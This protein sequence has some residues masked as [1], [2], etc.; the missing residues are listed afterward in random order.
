MTQN[1]NP[2]DLKTL[3]KMNETGNLNASSIQQYFP[4]TYMD[5]CKQVQERDEAYVVN[6]Y[7]G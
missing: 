6:R 2:Y 5:A 1:N 4:P 7:F 3:N